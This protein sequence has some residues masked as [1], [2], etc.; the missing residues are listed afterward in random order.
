MKVIH[1]GDQLSN[2]NS[3]TGKDMNQWHQFVDKNFVPNGRFVHSF[4]FEEP[5]QR[6]YH[7]IPR[8]NIGR[9]FQTYF[10][11]GATSIR[12]H[13]EHGQEMQMQPNRHQALFSRATFTVVY[14][15]GVRLE[16]VGSLSVVFAPQTDLIEYL[17]LGTNTSE[18]TIVRSKIEEVLSAWSPTMGNKQSSPRIA[19]KN[20]P[21]GQQKMQADS[22]TIENFPKIQKGSY[23]ITSRVQSFLEVSSKNLDHLA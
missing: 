19:K 21:K 15:N 3:A 6:K 22:L 13:S 1:F 16:M 17:E 7:E 18:E 12:L 11:T 8:A 20:I 10:D 5:N 2:F 23:G 9:Y 4:V 14:P